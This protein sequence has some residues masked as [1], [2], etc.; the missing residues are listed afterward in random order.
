MKNL[1]HI[2]ESPRDL[3]PEPKQRRQKM[4]NPMDSGNK[5]RNDMPVLHGVRA[6]V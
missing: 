2:E 5:S 6:Y 3:F 1:L 4:V